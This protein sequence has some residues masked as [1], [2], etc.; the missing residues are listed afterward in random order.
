MLW[1]VSLC[2]PTHTDGIDW[3]DRV[4]KVTNEC[5]EEIEVLW[6]VGERVSTLSFTHVWNEEK[7]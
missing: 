1:L 6:V 3:V 4:G 2:I 5:G 7:R